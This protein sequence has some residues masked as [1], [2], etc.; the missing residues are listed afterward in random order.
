ML[1]AIFVHFSYNIGIIY[2]EVFSV[3]QIEIVGD[4]YKGEY[5]LVRIACRAIIIRDGKILVSYETKS[6]KMMLP[7]GGIENDETNEECCVR[8]LAEET[9]FVVSPKEY[10]LEITEYYR[11][12]KF[13]HRYFIC[14]ITGETE[15]KLTKGEEAAGMEP[16]W[17]PI[18]DVVDIF[19]TYEQHSKMWRGLYYREYTALQNILY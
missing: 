7:G 19:G 5:H 1:R 14:D 2:Q 3:K 10:V 17:L 18:Q 6:N 4:N 8:E 16:R 11:K 13:I 15:R 9:G 12:A